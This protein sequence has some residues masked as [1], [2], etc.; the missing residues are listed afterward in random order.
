MLLC[1]VRRNVEWL[2]V[3]NNSSSSPRQN[4]RRRLPSTSVNNFPRYV[5]A[6]CIALGSRDVH[7]T[8]WSRILAENRLH[9]PNLHSTLPLGRSQLEYC[10]NVWYGKTRMVWLPDSE[11]KLKI[12]WFILTEFTNV[13]DGQTHRHRMTRQKWYAYS[14]FL[15]PSLLLTLI[16]F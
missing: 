14:T 11:K 16:T 5:A 3:I 15:V 7:S 4:K 13:T 6:E 8:R 2:P 12:C 10:H 9:V 1:C